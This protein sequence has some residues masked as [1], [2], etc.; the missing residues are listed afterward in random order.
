MWGWSL[1]YLGS[2]L[3]QLE[4][5]LTL[6]FTM[7]KLRALKVP[8]NIYFVNAENNQIGG[9]WQNGTLTCSDKDLDSERIITSFG[10]M[11]MSI[12]VPKTC[13]LNKFT[14]LDSPVELRRM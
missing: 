14:V 5:Q 10:F 13:Q 11:G 2:H 6:C 1:N 8:R 3:Y 9:A 12:A 4:R 7:S